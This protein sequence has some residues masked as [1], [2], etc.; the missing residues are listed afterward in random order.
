MYCDSFYT[1]LPGTEETPGLGGNCHDEIGLC[2]YNAHRLGDETVHEKEYK[3]VEKHGHL[4][5]FSL[6]EG[7]TGSVGGQENTGTERQKKCGWDD[8]FWGSDVRDHLL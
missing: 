6:H 7:H 1:R 4:T 5:R 2:E 8:Y 3:S